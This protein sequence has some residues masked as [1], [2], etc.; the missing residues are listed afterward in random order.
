MQI[1]PDTWDALICK[2]VIVD[3][4]Y[5]LPLDLR[6]KVIVDI[7]AHIGAFAIACQKRGAKSVT[8]YEADPANYELLLSNIA[9]DVESRTT[10]DAFNYAVVGRGRQDLYIRRL[11][12]HDFGKGRN[13][14]HVD[15]YGEEEPN[16]TSIP[17]P[18]IAINHVLATFAKVD[19]LKLDCE[20]A[21]WEM[22]DL[23][24]FANVDLILAELHA[25]PAG[26]H[27]AIAAYQN[28]SLPSLAD[29]AAEKLQ[30]AG[31]NTSVSIESGETAK[32]VATK[33]VVEVVSRNPRVLWV[34]DHVI[35][36]G[37]GRVNEAIC[38]RLV[39]LGWEVR[40]LG[41]GYNGDPHKLP[42]KVY[43][44]IDANIGGARNGM[45]R[46]RSLVDS[47]KPDV[48]V[49]HDDS[50]NVGLM[51]DN[52]AALNITTPVVGYIAVDSEN[53]REDHAVQLR[54]LKHAVCHTS[55]GVEQI[56][57]SGYTG[58][59]SVMPH[60]VDTDIYQPYDKLEARSGIP[61]KG[62]KPEDV[63][64]WGAVGM[65][66]PR[67]RLD[68]TLAYWAAWWKSEG[69]PDNAY[70]YVHTLADGVWD[71]KQLTEYLGIKG[72]MFTTEGGQILRDIEMPSLYSAFDVMISTSEGESFGIPTIEAM[73]CGVPNI[74][75]EC[76]GAPAWAGD[77]V[78]WVKPSQYSF[79]ATRINTKRWIASEKDFVQAMHDMYVNPGLRAEYSKRGLAKAASLNWDDAGRHFDKV[80]R[81]VLY[82][83]QVVA[84]AMND[85]LGEF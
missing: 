14:G 39:R 40:A 64:L 9:D 62:I 77:S 5:A 81:Q 15:I 19:I 68:L 54:N 1:R 32:L 29:R 41:I 20:G 28:N 57:K 12:N 83:R 72:R 25:V 51:V 31:F 21:E 13:T 3:N 55:F 67:K 10:V 22:F 80:M 84:S 79:T 75:V 43:P 45:S 44:A 17:L 76:G 7:G 38:R 42:Y 33:Q 73:A 30:R 82:S 71:L 37:F 26:N 59:S 85:A 74:Q 49:I 8:C 2:S 47:Y 23:C 66:Q 78:Y 61:V 4:E 70:L 60:G 36:T 6:G 24:D 11:S 65:N 63:F 46:M 52:M 50:W 27:P 56:V 48:I 53:V 69:K 35:T 16:H 58:P 34:G 18:C